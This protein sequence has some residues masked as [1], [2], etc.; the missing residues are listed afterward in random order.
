MGNFRPLPTKCWEAFL[1]YHGFQHSGRSKGSHFQW[2]KRGHRTIP[3]WED[4]KQIPALHLKTGCHTIGC[5]LTDL[6]EWADKNC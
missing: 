3:V 6:Y 4:E 1:T 5:T 2:T